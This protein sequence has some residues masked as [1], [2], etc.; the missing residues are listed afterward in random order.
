M[1]PG[2]RRILDRLARR[3][4]P[5]GASDALLATVVDDVLRHVRELPPPARRG[6][7]PAL[8]LFDQ[9]ALL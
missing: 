7:G 6:I 3:V 1:S 9:A 2:T 8:R 5:P 4:C